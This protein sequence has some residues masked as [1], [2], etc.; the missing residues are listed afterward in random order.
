MRIHYAIMSNDALESAYQAAHISW[1]YDALAWLL[2]APVGGVERLRRQA[3]EHLGVTPATRVLEL[4]CGSGGVT[5]RLVGLGASVTAVDW[6]GPMLEKA[7]RRAPAARFERSE[8]TAYT[9]SPPASF[10]LVLFCFVLHELD[11]EARAAALGVAARAL[12][13][14]GRVAIVDHALPRRGLVAR[15]LSRFVHGFEPP[16][17]R[18]WLRDGEAEQVLRDAGFEPGPRLLLASGLAFAL[19]A[20]RSET[21]A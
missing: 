14:G 15:A 5:C 3:L 17:S 13:P 18:A 21:R 11:H 12:S 10:D 16:S 9:P 1:G 20:R 4:G 6:S 19:E 7:A 2:F 8:L